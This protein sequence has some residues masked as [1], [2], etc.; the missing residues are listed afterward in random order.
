MRTYVVGGALDSWFTLA[1]ALQQAGIDIKPVGADS[2]LAELARRAEAE[3]AVVVLD[4]AADPEQGLARVLALRAASR[5]LALGV[6]AISPSLDLSQRLRVAGV[7]RVLIHPLEAPPVRTALLEMFAAIATRRAAGAKTVL[8]VDDDADFRTL[9]SDLLTEQ[10]FEVRTA[11]TGKE[12][13][14]LAIA[15]K[16]DLIVLDVMMENDWAGYEVNQTVKFQSGYESVR[17]TP[18]LM[19]SSIPLHPQDRFQSASEAAGFSPDSYISKPIEIPEFLE[20]VR[21]LLGLSAEEPAAH[22]P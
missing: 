18:I 8:I 12:G 13:L 2:D 6:A 7:H 5:T 20:K 19:I 3:G 9:I 10:G 4:L 22:R 16:P 1:G 21:A 11:S 14:A 17:H 15:E